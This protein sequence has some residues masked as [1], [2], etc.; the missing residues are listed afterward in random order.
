MQIK[1]DT[2]WVQTN[3]SKPLRGWYVYER[4]VTTSERLDDSGIREFCLTLA[5]KGQSPVAHLRQIVNTRGYENTFL[6]E[7]DSGD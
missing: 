5:S 3:R 2:D 4:T 1:H 7:L 6:C